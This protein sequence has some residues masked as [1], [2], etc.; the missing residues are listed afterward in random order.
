MQTT[1]KPTSN[2]KCQHVSGCFTSAAICPSLIEYSPATK[3]GSCIALSSIFDT[4]YLHR[5]SYFWPQGCF[6]TCERSC[7][8][9]GV[10]ADK[11]CIMCCYHHLKQ[12]LLTCAHRFVAC[13]IALKQ[14]RLTLVRLCFILSHKVRPH[15]AEVNRAGF[16]K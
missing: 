15:V 16:E 14:N 12:P 6:Y 13:K 11:W 9:F 4:S 1:E 3:K 10:L 7:S 2:N 8:L 5:T